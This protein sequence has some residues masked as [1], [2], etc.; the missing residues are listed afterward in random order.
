[1]SALI[2]FFDSASTGFKSQSRTD[3]AFMVLRLALALGSVSVSALGWGF[4]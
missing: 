1:M 3:L 2:M 4:D